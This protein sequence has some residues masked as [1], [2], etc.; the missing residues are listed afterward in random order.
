MKLLQILSKLVL[1]V[2]TF[3]I[4]H[5]IIPAGIEITTAR[6][7][8]KIVLSK[9]ERTIILENCGVL[10]GGNSSA[11]DD[12]SPFKIVLESSFETTNVITTPK[13]I[14]A[15]RINVEVILLK[16]PVAEPTKNIEI[17]AISVGNLPLQGTRLFVI[18][19]I[20]LSLGDSIILQPTT[21]AALQPN[22]IHIVNACFPQVFAFLK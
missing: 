19:A 13:T 15:K 5:I 20:S 18:I 11:N 4:N 17:I 9:T 6:D 3:A 16:N 1:S 12:G 10:N 21:P 22:P 7:N 8:T 2:V 14:T